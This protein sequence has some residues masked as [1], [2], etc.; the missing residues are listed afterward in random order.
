MIVVYLEWPKAAAKWSVFGLRAEL[1]MSR[2][3][4]L[5]RAAVNTVMNRRFNV[6]MAYTRKDVFFCDMTMLSLVQKY[7]SFRRTPCQ[8]FQH[9]MWRFCHLLRLFSLGP[10]S[11]TEC[12]GRQIFAQCYI[13]YGIIFF[14]ELQRK[15]KKKRSHPHTEVG[16]IKFFRNSFCKTALVR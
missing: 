13:T 4:A 3:L 15:T 1:R 8:I 6:L 7:W 16:R 9:L 11:L 5:W 2:L 10:L 12:W 14:L